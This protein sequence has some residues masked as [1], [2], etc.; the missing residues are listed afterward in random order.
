MKWLDLLVKL[1]SPIVDLVK[2]VAGS[3]WDDEKAADAFR[4]ML[5]NPPRQAIDDDHR[6]AL[7][8]IAEG[9]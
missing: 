3:D 9:E 1:A 5:R 4:E 2:A 6:E 7:R 8:A